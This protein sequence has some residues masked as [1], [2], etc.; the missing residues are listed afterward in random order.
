VTKFQGEN[1]LTGG[2]GFVG[3]PDLKLVEV[4]SAMFT[5][6][7]SDCKWGYVAIVSKVGV[8]LGS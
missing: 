8:Q 7:T 3:G 5:L 4:C 1:R 6:F 2:H